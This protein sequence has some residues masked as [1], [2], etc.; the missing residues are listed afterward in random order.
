MGTIRLA[1]L[2]DTAEQ[3]ILRF[4]GYSSELDFWTGASQLRR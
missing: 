3:P 4:T 1:G 2:A